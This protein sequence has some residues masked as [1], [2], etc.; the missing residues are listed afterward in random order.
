[1]PGP[2]VSVYSTDGFWI[3]SLR[4][5]F[6]YKVFMEAFIYDLAGRRIGR[7]S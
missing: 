4:A 1:M 5:V 3:I 6:L 7:G 2:G